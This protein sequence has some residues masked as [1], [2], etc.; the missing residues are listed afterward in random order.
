MNILLWLASS[1]TS[2]FLFV[3]AV[4]SVPFPAWLPYLP[5]TT[6]RHRLQTQHF[7]VHRPTGIVLSL[8][9]AVL[10]GRADSAF[11]VDRDMDVA[12][13]GIT[14]VNRAPGVPFCK[15][16]CV[17]APRYARLTTG[18]TTRT[19]C[20][21]HTPYH[22]REDHATLLPHTCTPTPHTHTPS[23]PATRTHATTHI[24]PHHT[25]HTP[26]TH[27]PP[28]HH[29]WW[30]MVHWTHTPPHAQPCTGLSH[31]PS[32]Q[33][34][35]PHHTTRLLLPPCLTSLAYHSRHWRRLVGR[36]WR[37]GGLRLP[38]LVQ[39]WRSG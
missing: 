30:N 21:I 37:E 8:R 10:A 27:P 35:A 7:V 39:E 24:A 11:M 33:H 1:C 32:Q 23:H 16:N 15:R 2:Y 14:M 28:L 4:P 38:Q 9:L 20:A 5:A 31:L 25:P 3:N 34:R 19:G 36:Q 13:H 17:T 29:C 22:G 6:G 26:F 12:P 18:H